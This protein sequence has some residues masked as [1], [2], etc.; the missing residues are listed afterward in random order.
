MNEFEHFTTS[1]LSG[2]LL[3]A[4][5]EHGVYMMN[6]IDHFYQAASKNEPVFFEKDKNKI[7]RLSS[8]F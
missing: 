1:I 3:M 8:S 6:I 4:P 2:D 5:A 7:L